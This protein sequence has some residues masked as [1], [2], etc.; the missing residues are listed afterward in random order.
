MG[1]PS[2]RRREILTERLAACAVDL[3][4]DVEVRAPA[5]ELI[6]AVRALQFFDPVV[7]KG[8]SRAKPNGATP[9]SYD[10]ARLDWFEEFLKYR[11]MHV[12]MVAY[13]TGA[14]GADTRAFV[15]APD[16]I[17]VR[18]LA[19]VRQNL[20]D[21]PV[22]GSIQTEIRAVIATT[23]VLVE[24]SEFLRL[25]DD[26]PFVLFDNRTPAEV[27]AGLSTAFFLSLGSASAVMNVSFIGLPGWFPVASIADAEAWLALM[28]EFRRSTNSLPEDRSEHVPVLQ[29][30]LRCLSSGSLEAAINFLSLYATVQLHADRTHPRFSARHLERIFAPMT[31]TDGSL[32]TIISSEGFRAVA[33]AIRRATVTEMFHKSKN[34]Q[35][36][37]I[38]YGLAQEWRRA[39]RVRN[40]FVNELTKFLS[41]YEYETA[42]KQEQ[43]DRVRRRRSRPTT[44]EIEEVIGL[45]DRFGS[46]LVCGLLLAFWFAREPAERDDQP[47]ADG[48]SNTDGR[49][50]A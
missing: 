45:V 18:V 3:G 37:E 19:N 31:T 36:Y 5:P 13:S 9:A 1:L 44:A 22:F 42:R 39:A 16:N 24:K 33:R 21:A 49:E 47:P 43:A 27:L 15:L 20:L 41:D 23:Q 11:A 8:A 50:D 30:M 10:S 29:A 34:Q 35:E 25:D 17:P 14:G 46:E 48:D 38:R 12:G 2:A 4:D 6:T 26:S 7:G 32:A 40:D 28:E